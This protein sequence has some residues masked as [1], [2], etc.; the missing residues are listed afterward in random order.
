MKQERFVICEGASS[1]TDAK[2]LH[3]LN[4]LRRRLE[5]E[6]GTVKEETL[7]HSENA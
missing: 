2:L 6:E 5:T 1:V 7:S 4:R 3:L